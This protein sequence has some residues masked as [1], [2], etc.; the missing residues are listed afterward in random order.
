MI[1]LA[2]SEY[3]AQGSVPDSD[4]IGFTNCHIEHFNSLDPTGL[5]PYKLKNAYY[6]LSKRG[7]DRGAKIKVKPKLIQTTAILLKINEKRRGRQPV[8]PYVADIKTATLEHFREI[9][10][11]HFDGFAGNDY[12]EIY[13]FSGGS[14]PVKIARDD[15]LRAVLALCKEKNWGTLTISLDSP[16]KNFSDYSWN[17]VRQQYGYDVDGPEFLPQFDIQ[18]RSVNDEEKI[19]LEEIIKECIRKNKAYIFGPSASEFTRNSIVDA[20]MVGAMQSYQANMFLAQQQPMIG[21][22]GRRKVDF[23]VM[24]RTHQTQ[25]LGVTEVK[26]DNHVRGMAQNM[27]ELDVAIQQKKR[28]RIEMDDDDD[29][30]PTTRLKSFGIVTDAFKWTFVECTLEADDTLTYKSK[31]VLRDL[32]LQEEKTL[33][34]DAD[35]LFGY[36]LSLYYRMKDEIVNR[37]SYFSPVPGSSSNANKRFASGER[38]T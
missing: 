31:E 35:T 5:P 20:F 27:V 16:F 3:I 6:H 24:D 29:E 9:L 25:V 18:P 8:C 13:A 22:R 28:K 11:P 34:E 7:S 10:C 32:R 26:K 4:T 36:V 17:G 23:A 14:V 21:R 2:P 33:R 19:N 30:R 37:S 15:D 1:V 38:Q 12:V